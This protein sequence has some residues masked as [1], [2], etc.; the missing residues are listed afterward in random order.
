MEEREREKWTE[1]NGKRYRNTLRH[2]Q[3]QKYC[4]YIDDI[5]VSI[6]CRTH[7][8]VGHRIQGGNPGPIRLKYAVDDVHMIEDKLHSAAA[9]RNPKKSPD[10]G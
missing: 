8:A 1:I 5:I 9:K 10:G 4:I 3:R 2:G 6:S 7:I